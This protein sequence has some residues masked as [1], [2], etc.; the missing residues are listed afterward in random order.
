ML[1]VSVSVLCRAARVVDA[2]HSPPLLG[3][4]VLLE[5]GGAF[6]GGAGAFKGGGGAGEGCDKSQ[7]PSCPMLGKF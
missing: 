4:R 5:G 6:E 1:S 3:A 7:A 2:P